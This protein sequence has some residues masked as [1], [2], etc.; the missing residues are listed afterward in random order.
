MHNKQQVFNLITTI[1]Q[2]VAGARETQ[3]PRRALLVS[4]K[5]VQPIIQVLDQ[6]CP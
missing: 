6:V 2:V 4:T 5:E 3:G 1:R